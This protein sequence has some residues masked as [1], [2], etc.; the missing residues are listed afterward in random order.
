VA[1]GPFRDLT[2]SPNSPN[3]MG[4][5]CKEFEDRKA[6]RCTLNLLD[7]VGQHGNPVEDVPMTCHS[8]PF[9]AFARGF[10]RGRGIFNG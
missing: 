6:I 8:Y 9:V 4:R 3:P 10:T 1:S 2:N 7:T 5:S